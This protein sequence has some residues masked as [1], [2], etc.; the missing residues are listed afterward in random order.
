MSPDFI[1]NQQCGLPATESQSTDGAVVEFLCEPPVI[2]RYI[3]LDIDP[4]T[5]DVTVAI[6]Q[7][8]EVNVQEYTSQECAGIAGKIDLLKI[9]EG[10]LWLKNR[11][12]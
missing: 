5:P 9:V 8:A 11:T 1:Q 2:A 7:I 10:A 12:K 4:S 6:L 3:S